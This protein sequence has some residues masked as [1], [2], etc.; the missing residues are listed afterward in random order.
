MR[1]SGRLPV[2]DAKIWSDP[3]RDCSEDAVLKSRRPERMLPSPPRL[4][5]LVVVSWDVEGLAARFL[6]KSSQRFGCNSPSKM[7]FD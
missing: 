7:R 5:G 1:R 6:K 3:S 4:E 2:E